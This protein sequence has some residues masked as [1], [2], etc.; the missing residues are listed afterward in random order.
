[1]DARITLGGDPD[2]E[3]LTSLY[4]WLDR[5]RDVTV[6]LVPAAELPGDMGGGFEVIA[7]VL[8]NGIALGSLI[9]AYLS[10]RDSRPKPPPVRIEY[11]GV[12]ITID[13][14][15]G[16]DGPAPTGGQADPDRQTEPEHPG[17]GL[18]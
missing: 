13:A 1:V 2:G 12:V 16:H 8:S 9:V 17:H 5:D 18:S 6:S 4:R 3:A 10:W 15:T 11:G 7:A 14:A